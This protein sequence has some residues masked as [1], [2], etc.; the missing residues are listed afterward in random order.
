[1]VQVSKNLR[2]VM[3]MGNDYAQ[4]SLYKR[5]EIIQKYDKHQIMIGRTR[6]GS[7]FYLDLKEPNRLGV[8]GKNGSGKTWLLRGLINRLKATGKICPF[9]PSDV[10]DEFFSNSM[11]LQSKFHHLLLPNEKPTSEKII[12]LRPTYFK[13]V[14]STLKPDTNNVWYSPDLTKISKA[15]FMLM[16]NINL[17]S[18]VQKAVVERLWTEFSYK[19]KHNPDDF[20]FRDFDMWIDS[21]DDLKPNTRDSMKRELA[22]LYNSQFYE[23]SHRKSLIQLMKDG[24]T[25]SINME[26]YDNFKEGKFKLNETLL[27]IAI[28][29]LI[30]ARKEKK[31]Y[32]LFI[33]LEEAFRFFPLL[34]P[35]IEESYDV[36]RRYGVDWIAVFQSFSQMTK[37]MV[38]QTR[39]YF[40]P[41]NI[42]METFK[43]VFMG[44]GMHTS[45]QASGNEAVRA[46][47][48]MRPGS[49]EWGVF[50]KDE[51]KFTV[52]KPLAPL[53]H[54]AEAEN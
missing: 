8:I 18:E 29:E 35:L 43:G 25:I 26:N 1:M 23:P 49:H 17:L 54:H 36:D 30:T 46:F 32:R 16:L 52:I 15:N 6:T 11:P 48:Q 45:T 38:D 39:F 53:C 21:F 19:I 12:V 3:H 40:V 47:R 42:D 27:A 37:R 28:S 13:Q 50:D 22:P 44:L 41:S 9:I 34:V 24:Y 33:F 7:I 31:I 2:H 4:R 10:K 5:K 20:T 14:Y 51:R